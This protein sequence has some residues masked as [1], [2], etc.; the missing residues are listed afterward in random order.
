M[1]RVNRYFSM[2]LIMMVNLKMG[3][4]TGMVCISGMTN[5]FTR[6]T[7]QIMVLMVKENIGGLMGGSILANGETI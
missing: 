2:A 6:G 4:R 1:D 7:G 3:R 5:L